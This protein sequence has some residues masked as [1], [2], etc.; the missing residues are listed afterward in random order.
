MLSRGAITSP[1]PAPPPPPPRV[2]DARVIAE[3]SCQTINEAHQS[4]VLHFTPL[5]MK[6]R[7]SRR[8]GGGGFDFRKTTEDLEMEHLIQ[9]AVQTII[10]S[11]SSG[12]KCD[13]CLGM[14]LGNERRSEDRLRHGSRVITKVVDAGS[15]FPPSNL[16]RTLLSLSLSPSLP[17]LSALLPS[18]RQG[19]EKR[20]LDPRLGDKARS[21]GIRGNPAGECDVA[22]FLSLP[23]P[24]VKVIGIFERK[25]GQ[26]NSENP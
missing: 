5:E 2:V 16:Q 19:L 6:N 12:F 3:T 20:K 4:Q 22:S 15:S 9:Q 7:G 13:H 25:R 17:F 21:T 23:P 8:R 11:L 18:C 24:L 26:G 1:S 14:A 10:S